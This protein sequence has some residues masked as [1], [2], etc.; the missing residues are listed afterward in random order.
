[1]SNELKVRKD[2]NEIV[3]EI[4]FKEEKNRFGVRRFVNVVL[5]NGK[6][7]QFK[8]TEGKFD[9]FQSYKDCGQTD[10]IKSKELIDE[11][12]TNEEGEPVGIY[13]CVKY[14]LTDGSIHR[15]FAGRFVDDKIISNYY[16]LYK[17]EK[18]A[19]NA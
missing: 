19:K 8:D 12:K 13:T 6:A 2:L 4:G 10:F 5:F 3:K 11:I 17:K 1:M 7:I 18:K 14:E 16:E 9:L 15:F